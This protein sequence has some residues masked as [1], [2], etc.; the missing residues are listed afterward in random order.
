MSEM[1]PAERVFAQPVMKQVKSVAE[2]DP[3]T[4]PGPR[5]PPVAPKPSGVPQISSSLDE[6]LTAW[7]NRLRFDDFT[8]VLDG[9]SSLLDLHFVVTEGELTAAQLEEHGLPKF[10][11]KRFIREVEKVRCKTCRLTEIADRGSCFMMLCQAASV[12]S[13]LRMY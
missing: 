11:V 6:E 1:A 7:L 4:S 2:A 10:T 8:Q 9:I 5:K 13:A 12:S 3:H